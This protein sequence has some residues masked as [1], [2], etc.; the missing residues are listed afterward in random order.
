MFK[1]LKR[2]I[3]QLDGDYKLLLEDRR[4]LFLN[5]RFYE[6]GVRKA[7]LAILMEQLSNDS[8]GK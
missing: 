1:N 5:I 8:G 3:D 7:L 2:K 6:E 4:Q